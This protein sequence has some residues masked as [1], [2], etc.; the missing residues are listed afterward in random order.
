M[1]P[2]L[3]VLLPVRNAA[4]WLPATLRSLARQTFRDF[5]IV[6]VDDGST[7]DS[8]AQLERAA[9][10][11]ARLRVVRSTARGLPSALTLALAT[12]RAPILARQDADDISHRERFARQ[13]AF[14]RAHRGVAAVGCRLRLFPPAD[15]GDG[16]RR[17]VHW[18][19]ALLTH[20][21]MA[22]EALID[23][24]LAHGTA[25]IRRDALE[26]AGSWQE[27][28]WPEDVDLWLRML[29]VR[30]RLAKLPDVLYGWRQ[31]DGS[32][33]RRDPRY[34]PERYAELRCEALR[35][36]LLRRARRLTL[37]GVGASLAGWRIRLAAAGFDAHALEMPRPGASARQWRPPI[38]LVFG[39]VPARTRWREGLTSLRFVEGRD[40][41]FVA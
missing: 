6:A 15:S 22:R 3:S 35:L 21:E 41:V 20:E 13:F 29:R 11:D 2:A 7:D 40:F 36:G 14:L 28:G 27:R 30:A 32:A 5:E 25:M 31:H 9:A 19:N 4:A 16:M 33:T 34:A 39:A 37:V 1:T 26:R 23:S 18:H 12:A 10:T 17:W 8:G 24:P 38:V